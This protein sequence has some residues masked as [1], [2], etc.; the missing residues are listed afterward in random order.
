MEKI[1]KK[2]IENQL[3]EEY[4]KIKVAKLKEIN[5]LFEYKKQEIIA[6]ILNGV[7]IEIS[8]NE[9]GLE[10]NINIQIRTTRTI[11]REE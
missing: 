11:K 9:L 8:R 6:G 4:E 5:S 2:E 7:S 3:C 10:P 1:I